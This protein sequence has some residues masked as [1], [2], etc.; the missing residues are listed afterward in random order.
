MTQVKFDVGKGFEEVFG[1]QAPLFVA[2]QTEVDDALPSFESSEAHRE[3]F[4]SGDRV[5]ETGIVVPDRFRFERYG[6][7][8]SL[9]IETVVDTSRG[10][11]IV[12]TSMQGKDGTIKEYVNMD[13]WVLVIQGFLINYE[14]M[15]YPKKL[16]KALMDFFKSNYSYAVVSDFL[17]NDGIYN[18]VCKEIRFPSMAGHSNVQ[19][20]EMEMWS[21]EPLELDLIIK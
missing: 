21:D 4:E 15:T 10:K 18:V 19:P 3:D 16:K 2:S 12:K 9:P 14:E 11:N 13:D 6:E 7:T 8:F 17:T 5:A 1:V 20:F